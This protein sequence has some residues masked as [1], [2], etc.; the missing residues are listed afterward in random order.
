MTRLKLLRKARTNYTVAFTQF[1]KGYTK[2][3]KRLFCFFEGFDSKYYSIRINLV[4]GSNGWANLNCNGKDGIIQLYSLI[5]SNTI[6]KNANVAFF[7]DRDFGLATMPQHPLVYITP[8]YSV[9]NFYVTQSAFENILK[10]ELQIT[11]L[12]TNGEY[13]RIL[14]LYLKLI[15]KFNN[16]TEDLNSWIYLNRKEEILGIKPTRLNLNTVRLNKLVD[17]DLSGIKKMYNLIS[18]SKMFPD[19][20]R[21]SWQEID[22]VSKDFRKK[23]RCT[24]FRGKYLIEFLRI[25]ILLLK[26]ESSTASPKYIHNKK[27]SLNISRIN[28][29]SELSQYAD[30][31]ACLSAFL[32]NLATHCS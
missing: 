2:N 4:L 6:Y 8:C 1:M 22:G 30:T 11:D 18:L 20:K 25:F 5:F 15:N 26:Q 32:D 23:D 7:L 29:L 27:I 31:P 17:I 16:T 24:A 14:N 12:D 9:E 28:I 19:S 13:K 21:F 10:N 3:P